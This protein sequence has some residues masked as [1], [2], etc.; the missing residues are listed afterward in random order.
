MLYQK[1]LQPQCLYTRSIKENQETYLHSEKSSDMIQ[2]VQEDS[3]LTAI[4]TGIKMQKKE[5]SMKKRQREAKQTK[6]Y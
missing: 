1:K 5:K 2:G 4:G 3:W 6:I